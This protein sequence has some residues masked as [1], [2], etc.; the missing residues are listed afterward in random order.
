MGVFYTICSL[1]G[2]I[3]KMIKGSGFSE[4]V[5]ESGIC[6]SGSLC[7]VMSGKHFNRALWVH[8]LLF[9]ALERLLLTRF[10]EKYKR[11]KCLSYD[12]F[13]MLYRSH[14]N[15]QRGFEQGWT[16]CEIPRLHEL[17]KDDKFKSEVLNGAHDKTSWFLARYVDIIQTRFTLIGATKAN[18]LDLHHHG[19]M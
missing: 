7:R 16:I 4:T 5:I 9:K 6:G 19:T 8:K 14:W 13:A 18:D 10:E 15:L 1:F 17:W 2:M 12:T 3:G 11:D